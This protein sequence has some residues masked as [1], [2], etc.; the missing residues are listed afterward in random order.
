MLPYTLYRLPR[1][2]LLFTSLIGFDLLFQRV[3]T[4]IHCERCSVCRRLKRLVFMKICGLFNSK[5]IN[6]TPLPQKLFTFLI[7][8]DVCVILS[9]NALLWPEHF[10]VNIFGWKMFV[11]YGSL[12]LMIN[13]CRY[14]LPN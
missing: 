12:L 7:S 1:L 11:N 5:M 9:T 13:F 3:N 14:T 10:H 2:Y 6:R 8:S 4:Y